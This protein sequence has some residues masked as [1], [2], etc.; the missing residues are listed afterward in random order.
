MPRHLEGKKIYLDKPELN[1]HHE[2]NRHGHKWESDKFEDF[3]K[4]GS[5]HGPHHGKH[6]KIGLLVKLVLFFAAECLYIYFFSQYKKAACEYCETN[7]KYEAVVDS[8]AT[9]ESSRQETYRQISQVT[10]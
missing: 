6:K 8:E 3:R 10:E 7:K 5:H 9:N 1:K 2:E 4:G